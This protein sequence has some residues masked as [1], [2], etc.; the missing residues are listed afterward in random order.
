MRDY[1]ELQRLV[2]L[3]LA[4]LYLMSGLQLSVGSK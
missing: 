1:I 4:G 3:M 2:E